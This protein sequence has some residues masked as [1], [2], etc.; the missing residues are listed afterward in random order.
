M[1]STKVPMIYL[2]FWLS[3]MSTKNS[4]IYNVLNQGTIDMPNFLSFIDMSKKIS[5]I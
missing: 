5:F 3:N 4:F 1:L 2:T